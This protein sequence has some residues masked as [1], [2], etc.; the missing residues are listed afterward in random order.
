MVEIVDAYSDF[1]AP[2]DAR[3]GVAELLETVPPQHLNGL[4]YVRLTNA[5]ALKGARKR[6][7]SWSRGRKVKHSEVAGL[8]HAA[9]QGQ[10][11]C[12]ELFVDQIFDGPPR[13]L[14]RWR[15]VRN[16]LLADVLF[17]ELGHHIH[18]V[19]RPEHREREA[20][21]EDWSRRLSRHYLR[22]RHSVAWFTLRPLARLARRWYPRPR[23]VNSR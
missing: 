8:Y 18:E 13:W 9:W 5:A 4:R 23:P 11:A 2:C 16:L 19:E 10:P 1:A 3:A 22:R 7:R 15:L 12:I 20:V 14:L 21:A 6:G 17:H